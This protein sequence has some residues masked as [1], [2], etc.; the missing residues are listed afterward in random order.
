MFVHVIYSGWTLQRTLQ[1]RE[2]SGMA[3][4]NRKTDGGSAKGEPNQLSW[5]APVLKWTVPRKLGQVGHHT[6][7]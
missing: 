2:G 3:E 5:F 4:A 6:S 7:A 1:G